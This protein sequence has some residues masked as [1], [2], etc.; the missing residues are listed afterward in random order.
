MRTDTHKPRI[1]HIAPHAVDMHGRDEIEALLEQFA[2]ALTAGDGAAAATYWHAPVFIMGDDH[3]HVVTHASEVAAFF[4][5]A[6][7]QYAA[8]GIAGTRPEI[9]S[10]DWLTE[11]TALVTVRWP[12]LDER[13]QQVGEE[14]STYLVKAGPGGTLKLRAAIMHGASDADETRALSRVDGDGWSRDS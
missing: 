14:A 13:G 10:L 12:W 7:A 11:R 6:K 1:R 3:E 8:R 5:G 4:G 9:V 2:D